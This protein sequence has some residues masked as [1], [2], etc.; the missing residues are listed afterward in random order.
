MYHL[1]NGF[2]L[3]INSDQFKQATIA[4]D[5]GE[6]MAITPSNKFLGLEVSLRTIKQTLF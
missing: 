1:K 3:D 4:I 5:Q 2:V 6:I